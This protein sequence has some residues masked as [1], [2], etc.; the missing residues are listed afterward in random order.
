MHLPSM[1]RTDG[2]VHQFTRWAV[3]VDENHTRI[4]FFH[5]IRPRSTLQWIYEKIHFTIWN[6]WS[7]NINFNGQDARQEIYQYYDKPEKLTKSDAWTIAWRKLQMQARGMPQPD[8]EGVPEAEE[9]AEFDEIEKELQAQ[10]V[11]TSEG[12]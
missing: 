5:S 4:W 12:S 8:L 11:H 2:D 7:K 1:V 9:F 10:V 3:P 6:D